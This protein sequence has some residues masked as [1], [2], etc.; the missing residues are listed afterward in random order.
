MD[1]NSPASLKKLKIGRRFITAGEAAYAADPR[2][3]DSLLH[4]AACVKTREVVHAQNLKVDTATIIASGRVTANEWLAREGLRQ[5]GA[6]E[7]VLRETNAD[8][9]PI[10]D[11]DTGVQRNPRR[12]KMMSPGVAA[13]VNMTAGTA[14]DM[15]RHVTAPLS[16]QEA[17]PV[18]GF[19][20]LASQAKS[21]GLTAINAARTTA[22]AVMAY[23]RAKK[24]SPD[25]KTP[26]YIH[27][28]QML[29]G[30]KISSTSH[31]LG[32]DNDAIRQHLAAKVK[33]DQMKELEERALPIKEGLIQEMVMR[34]G[35]VSSV[36]ASGLSSALSTLESHRQSKVPD[37]HLVTVIS[38]RQ[39]NDP[40][41]MSMATDS[42]QK[43]IGRSAAARIEGGSMTRR[44]NTGMSR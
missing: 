17:D 7:A 37:S 34:A 22:S 13:A 19:I 33:P 42:L 43:Q 32:P 31:A 30:G 14:S 28:Y 35:P 38:R 18:D 26:F 39:A 10:T 16:P 15:M 5:N 21:V 44:S 24:D 6:S 12:K 20:R 2:Q 41:L 25:N 40:L 4:A 3:Y 9:R 36:T 8:T 11:P 1:L 23:D 29:K 27:V